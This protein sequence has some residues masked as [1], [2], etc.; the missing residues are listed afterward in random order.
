MHKCI[1][2]MILLCILFLFVICY[3]NRGVIIPRGDNPAEPKPKPKPKPNRRSHY[4]KIKLH[5]FLS[6]ISGHI[7]NY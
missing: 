4:E 6:A 7:T 2:H 5:E 1:Q 3:N